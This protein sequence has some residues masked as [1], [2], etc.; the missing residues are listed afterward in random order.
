MS[1]DDKELPHIPLHLVTS[2]KAPRKPIQATELLSKKF[3][4][5][6]HIIGSGLLNHGGILILGAPAKSY[7]SFMGNTLMTSLLVGRSL[8]G[9]VRKSSSGRH[10]PKDVFPISYPQRVLLLEQ[11]VGEEDLQAR[12]L[13]ILPTL[14]PAELKLFQENLYTHSCDFNM[15][16]DKPEGR[17][18]IGGLIKAAKPDILYLDPLIDFHTSNE[19]DSQVM[20]MIL[21]NIT[22]L[23]QEHN[24]SV[25]IN[26]HIGHTRQDNPRRGPDLLRGSSV[27]FAKGD[28]FMMLERTKK[29]GRIKVSFTLRRGKPISGLYVQLNPETLLFEFEKWTK[30]RVFS[31]A[32][33][34][35]FEELE[36]E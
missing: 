32:E 22:A 31:D 15:V 25:I 30:S 23:R 9:A 4:P 24:L 8:F 33:L 18:Y 6:T 14:S 5:T 27:I 12:L 7:K 21:H 34:A 13:P 26:H 1:D 17:K 10:E 3:L 29:E 20:S 16:F 36:D 2:P 35:L 28:S 11:E 19:N